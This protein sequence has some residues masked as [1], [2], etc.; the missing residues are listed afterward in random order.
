MT[1]FTDQSILLIIFHSNVTN[2]HDCKEQQPCYI[3]RTVSLC[4]FIRLIP[5][6]ILILLFVQLSKSVR[7]ISASFI[8]FGIKHDSKTFFHSYKYI[9]FK[10]NFQ[11]LSVPPPLLRKGCFIL[12]YNMKQL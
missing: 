8:D 4:L 6:S 1:S 2:K 3:V 9:V 5:L 11:T 10:I 12:F 7:K